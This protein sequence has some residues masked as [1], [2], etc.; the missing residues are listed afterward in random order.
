M[1][2]QAAE[3]H[4]SKGALS[5]RRTSSD[6]GSNRRDSLSVDTILT[7]NN[8]LNSQ[9][10]ICTFIALITLGLLPFYLYIFQLFIIVLSYFSLY[11]LVTYW[12]FYVPHYVL[13]WCFIFLLLCSVDN[14]RYYQVW[15]AHNLFSIS[16]VFGWV[17]IAYK[18]TV[19]VIVA[20]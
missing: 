11:C 18:K 19:R 13:N 17:H 7:K 14:L 1:C 9:V 3:A 8:S 4:K 6:V 16:P 12:M 15:E 20:D 10:K 5:R 2:E